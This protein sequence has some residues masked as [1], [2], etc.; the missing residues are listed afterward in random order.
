MFTQPNAEQK[1]V[2][3]DPDGN[4]VETWI[5]VRPDLWNM[6]AT[7]KQAESIK[8]KVI[9][10]CPDAQLMDG[11]NLDIWIPV[12][13]LDDTTKIWVYKGSIKGADGNVRGLDEYAGCLRDRGIKPNPFVDGVGGP[14]LIAVP[15]TVD[16]VQCK[17][18]KV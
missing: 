7:E 1:I 18:G 4:P 5:K 10:I 6:F 3:F 8:A 9:A 17:W 12:R 11:L 14:D 13:Y 15:I 2:E 16:L